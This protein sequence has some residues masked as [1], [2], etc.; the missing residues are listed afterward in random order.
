MPC[1]NLGVISETSFLA[2]GYRVPQKAVF[3]ANRVRF[4]LPRLG[5][6]NKP[7]SGT[8]WSFPSH[9]MARAVYTEAADILYSH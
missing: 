5:T 1:R 3:R 7:A 4:T 6:S 2:S 9:P 8:V